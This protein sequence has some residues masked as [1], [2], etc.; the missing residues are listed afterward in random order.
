MGVNFLRIIYFS[1]TETTKK[2]LEGIGKGI[3]SE[4]I[5]RVD[6]TSPKAENQDFDESYDELTLIGAPVYGG[7]IPVDAKNRLN[8]LKANNSPAAVVVVYGN[9]EYEDALLELRDIASEAGFKPI[10]GGAFI[11]EHSFAND[12]TPI[13]SGRPDPEDLNRAEEFGKQIRLKLEG[14][15]KVEDLSIIQVPGNFP[16]KKRGKRLD[17]ISPTVK[18]ELCTKCGNC[19]MGCPTEAITLEAK[20][21]IRQDACILCCACIK[22]CP[23]QAITMEH[24]KIK[25]AAEWLYTDYR[26]RKEPEIYI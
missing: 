15:R 6:L 16:Y 1:P 17:E 22:N 2:V 12:E 4:I 8:R 26:E 18:E 11:G 3:Q 10:A 21:M 9:R 24:P 13:A 20:I 19:A 14:N 25:K 7:R 23:T 5:E